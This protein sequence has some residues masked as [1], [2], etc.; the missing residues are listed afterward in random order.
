MKSAA[1]YKRQAAEAEARDTYFRTKPVSTRADGSPV[2]QKNLS[3]LFY[4]SLFIREGTDHVQF[5]VDVDTVALGMVSLAATGLT[6]VGTAGKFILPVR[7]LLLPTRGS[8]Y[9]GTATP[10]IEVTLWQS[11]YAKYHDTTGAGTEQRS[12]YSVPI[13]SVGATFEVSD[14]INKFNTIF[15][16]TGTAGG[17]VTLLGAKNGRAELRIEQVTQ[18]FST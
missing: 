4:R 15:Q 16:G 17:N 11:R 14:I 2:S 8:W 7:N 6:N 1:Y 12:H 10:T 9:K 13:S 3:Q 5:R 18:A